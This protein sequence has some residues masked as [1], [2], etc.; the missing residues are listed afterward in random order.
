VL[1]P[2][3]AVGL[4]WVAFAYTG[5]SASAYVA[6]EVA[7]PARA[8]PRALVGG[9]LL[10]S[11]LYLAL[12]A[13]F[14]AAAPMADLVGQVK[15]GHVA[16]CHLLGRVGG[17]AITAIVTVGLVSTVGA[18]IV[19]GPRIYEAVGRDFPR[20]RWL[21]DRGSA[22]GPRLATAL[23]SALA[24]V[25]MLS[26]RFDALLSYM[27][28]TLSVFG[29]LAVCGVFVLRRRGQ[30]SRFRMPGYPLTPLLF[31]A[32][33]AWMVLWGM[34]ET[35][36]SALAGLGTVAVGLVVYRLCRGGRTSARG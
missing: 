22:G 25:M 36:A 12:N 30:S 19:T 31:V 11:V 21:T 14:L 28:F 15:I 7:D 27:G 5:W 17:R 18:M 20:L 26:A 34:L 10:V 2:G 33:M 8:L 32:L 24:L 3:F 4:L 29:A 13:V 35:P 1:S 23:Q 16:A 6:G 9:T